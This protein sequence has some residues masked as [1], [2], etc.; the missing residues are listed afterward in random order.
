[1]TELATRAS[2]LAGN[3]S[4]P[5][6]VSA[7]WVCQSV[8]TRPCHDFQQWLKL[9]YVPVSVAPWQPFLLHRAARGFMLEKRARAALWTPA[10]RLEGFAQRSLGRRA[11]RD[12]SLH[13]LPESLGGWSDLL[14]V[15]SASYWNT[16][17]L[18]WAVLQRVLGPEKWTV[19]VQ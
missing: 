1:M 14:A 6:G 3:G 4:P 11:Q 8:N 16:R 12:R 13:V 5:C 10:V 2:S 17:F 19:T 9:P 15:T 7:A 18:S